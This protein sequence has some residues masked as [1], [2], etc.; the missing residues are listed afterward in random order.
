MS[1]SMELLA[2]PLAE[3]ILMG[4]LSGMVGALAVISRRVFFAES[5]THATFPG[6]VAGVVVVTAAGTALTGARIGYEILSIAVLIGAVLMCAPMTWLMRRLSELPGISSQAAAGIVLSLGFALGHLLSTWFAPLP[7][8]VDGFL[9]GS[10]L[11]VN[12]ADVAL[13]VMVLTVTVVVVVAAG[14]HLES[15]CFDAVAYRAVGLNPRL[16]ERTVLVLI[17]LNIGVLIPAVGTILPIALI[18]A[19]AAALRSRA[20]S[21]SGLLIGSAALGAGCC[22]AGLWLAVLLE[23]SAGGTIA[24]ICGL[25]YAASRIR[26]VR[27]PG[28]RAGR[29]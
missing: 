24:V 1:V 18:A 6:A 20:R 10:V 12:H 11:N 25:V 22:L 17:C 8:K 7:L 4:T 28:R 5:I 23:W 2:L 29:S 26:H 19:P 14:H 13:T 21:V 16:P 27:F 9:T 15:Y 3:T